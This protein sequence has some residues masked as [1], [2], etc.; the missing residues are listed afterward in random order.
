[1]TGLREQV[2]YAIGKGNLTQSDHEETCADI[3][4]AFAM[5]NPLGAA[6][7]RVTGNL[8]ANALRRAHSLLT[9]ELLSFC[10]EDTRYMEAV[11]T[12]A[13]R[14]WLVC[15]CPECGGR[16]VVKKT[17]RPMRCKSCNGTGRGKYD[18]RTREQAVGATTRIRCAELPLVL[19]K[20][21]AIMSDADRKV[22]LEVGAQLERSVLIPKRK[23]EI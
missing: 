12:L 2:A 14:E 15:L 5:A 11:S 19:E 22:E 21:H 23:I 13:L 7:W 4:G 8:D 20:A 6:L 9:H 3:L 17:T 18:D 1:M 16:S 10:Q